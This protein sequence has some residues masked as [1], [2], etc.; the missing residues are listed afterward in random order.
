MEDFVPWVSP[1]SSHPPDCEEEE[2]EDKMSDLV[3]KF[4]ARKRKRDV[5][6]KGWLMPSRGGQGRGLGCLS[7]SYLRL[8]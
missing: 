3:H 8:A 4:A 7:N 6:F 1:M 2:E 5:S